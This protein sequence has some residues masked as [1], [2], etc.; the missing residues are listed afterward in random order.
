ML[1][2]FATAHLPG[3]GGVLKE[4]P[5]DFLVEEQALYE[6]SGAGEHLYLFIEKTGLTTDEAVRRVC[7]AFGVGRG[8]VGVAGL[9]DKQAVTR[10]WLSIHLPGVKDGDAARAVEALGAEPETLRVAR[11]AR[12]GNKLRLGHH[13]GNRFV[14]KVRQVGPEAVLRAKP[15]LDFLA[16]HGAPDFV[17]DQRFGVEGD[18]AQMGRLLLAGEAPPELRRKRPE[19]RAFLVSAFQSAVF[20]RL[21]ALRVKQG[22]W[23]RLLEGDL[24]MKHDNGAVFAADGAVAADD[25]APGGRVEKLEVSPSGP[26][27]GATMIRPTGVPAELEAQALADFGFTP[28]TLAQACVK[29]GGDFAR[30]ARRPLR[31][32]VRE[33]ALAFSVDVDGPRLELAF[34]LPKG[35]YATEVMREVMK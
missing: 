3:T 30:G 26:L 1:H 10:Q 27:W 32:P 29:Y 23:D 7:R 31:I 21:L 20:N 8:A 25:N 15:V 22:S 13:A 19:E 28:E 17:G 11:A 16:R 6:P 34:L 24:A 9:K 12:H 35:A 2:P 18:N 4:R 5:G 33:T 14:L